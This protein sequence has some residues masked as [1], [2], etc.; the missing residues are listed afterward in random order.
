MKGKPS[1]ALVFYLMPH[2]IDVSDEADG[3]RRTLL[4]KQ[5]PITSVATAYL[6][7]GQRVYCSCLQKSVS[8]QQAKLV[9]F[10]QCNLSKIQSS[11][12]VNKY[13]TE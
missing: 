4:D 3:I 11:N 5:V 6:V 7:K 8:A 2:L 9:I 13:G 1:S 12:M 10:E